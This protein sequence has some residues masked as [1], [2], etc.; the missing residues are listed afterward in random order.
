MP[1]VPRIVVTIVAAVALGVVSERRAGVRAHH[2]RRLALQ[3]ML[4]VLVPF[5]VYVNIARLH[6]TVDA[7]L[8]L[9][10]AAAAV[11]SSGFLMWRLG[12]GP[13]ALPR[14]A[15]GAAIV[16]T[17]QA[18]TAYLGLPLCATVFAH[19]ELPRA[20]AY[21]SLVSLPMFLFGGYSVGAIFGERARDASVGKRLRGTFLRHPI[22]LALVAGL[23][24]PS[25]WAPHALVEPAR[26]AVFALLPLGFYAV[27]VTLADEAKDGTLRIPPSLT[28]PV[29]TV[30]SLRLLL[31]PA[32]LLAASALI[33]VPAPFFLLAAMPV[34]VNTLI[35]GHATG[36][37]LRL[38]ASSITW[39]TT[40]VLLVALVLTF[41]G[42]LG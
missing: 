33:A 29:A 26:I 28:P 30:G 2:A 14:P 38:T 42:V 35:V 13:L 1:G 40:V 21:D 22:L 6:L 25:T 12:K 3:A 31:A 39:T 4:W 24:V 19:A 5:V 10:I 23:V 32:A 8:S 7:G 16:C 41:A 11:A 36:L 17:I 18:N 27:G 15:T 34:G 20:V 37:D 9:A